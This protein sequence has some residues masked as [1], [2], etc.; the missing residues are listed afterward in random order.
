MPGQPPP[1]R[2]ATAVQGATCHGEAVNGEEATRFDESRF[3]VTRMD[4]PAVIAALAPRQE[5][6]L[7]VS[8]DA[9]G[10]ACEDANVVPRRGTMAH[11]CCRRLQ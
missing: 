6:P 8:V 3:G 9:A 7:I 11:K 5:G 4:G 1:S 10:R 2:D